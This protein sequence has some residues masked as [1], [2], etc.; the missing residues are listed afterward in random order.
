MPCLIFQLVTQQVT[1][2]LL[3]RVEI[4]NIALHSPFLINAYMNV[5][6]DL[7]LRLQVTEIKVTIINWLK[8]WT[9]LLAHTFRSSE[10]RLG[11]RSENTGIAQY[12]EGARPL[13]SLHSAVFEFR[14][15]PRLVS[16]AITAPLLTS[17]GVIYEQASTMKNVPLFSLMRQ[18]QVA[19]HTSQSFVI[20][21]L[22]LWSWNNTADGPGLIISHCQHPFPPRMSLHSIDAWVM[23]GSRHAHSHK[24]QQTSSKHVS[25]HERGQCTKNIWGLGGNGDWNE[26]T[27]LPTQ[28]L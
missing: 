21:G 8:Y 12:N 5:R 17:S 25:R 2:T 4:I 18:T 3:I 19:G 24:C 16:F 9:D 22:G 13:C 7:C 6:E 15:I 11:P 1:S 23:G 10:I 27:T 20:T 14:F 28:L 26:E